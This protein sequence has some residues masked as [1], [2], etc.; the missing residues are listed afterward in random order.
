MPRVVGKASG[1]SD[2]A[3][4]GVVTYYCASLLA[5]MSLSLPSTLPTLGA[6]GAA[7]TILSIVHMMH[8]P[9]PFAR[10]LM[11]TAVKVSL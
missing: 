1:S 4:S 10:A 5:T 7:S 3:L 8:L 9:C 6:H 2:I 11:V